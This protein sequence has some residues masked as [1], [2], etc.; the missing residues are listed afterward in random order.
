MDVQLHCIALDSGSMLADIRKKLLVIILIL[1]PRCLRQVYK[2]SS[3]ARSDIFDPLMMLDCCMGKS[4]IMATSKDVSN[5]V[6]RGTLG[7]RHI[8]DWTSLLP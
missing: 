1:N 5:V 6:Q 4:L 3:A 2:Y 7:S 8:E